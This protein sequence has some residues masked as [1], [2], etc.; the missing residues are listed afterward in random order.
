MAYQRNPLIYSNQQA[1]RHPTE[2]ISELHREQPNLVRATPIAS[3]LMELPKKPRESR[4]VTWGNDPW[5]DLHGTFTDVFTNVDLQPGN[6]YAGG[7][8]DGATLYVQDSEDHVNGLVTGMGILYTSASLG[9]E[10]RA[11]VT[12]ISAAGANSYV[13]IKLLEADTSNV[14]AQAYTDVTWEVYTTAYSDV[15][16]LP[17]GVSTE[18]DTY[19]NWMQVLMGSHS[20]SLSAKSELDQFDPDEVTLNKTKAM[21]RFYRILEM[22]VLRGVKRREVITR[23]S[24]GW[25]SGIRGLLSEYLPA[26]IIDLP[27][28][29]GTTDHLYSGLNW[30]QYGWSAWQDIAEQIGRFSKASKKRVY[31]GSGVLRSVQDLVEYHGLRE[32]TNRQTEFGTNV[33]S[34]FSLGTTWEFRESMTMTLSPTLRNTAWAMDDPI[35]AGN[36]ELAPLKDMD[37]F[38]VP[39]GEKT[40]G[41]GNTWTQLQKGGWVMHATLV[42]KGFEQMAWIT[43]WGENNET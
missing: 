21:E 25:M 17:D 4:T 39:P 37:L 1:V 26:N 12:R 20:N 18:I 14:L 22:T 40:Q 41:P 3:L 30:R 28:L 16:G 38:Y 19:E 32:V 27:A 2:F 9:A 36:L 43:G 11:A 34:F 6:A 5:E 15:A 24:Y 29:P 7:G 35:E 13:V 42:A 8:V 23:E 33:T 31:C 10:V